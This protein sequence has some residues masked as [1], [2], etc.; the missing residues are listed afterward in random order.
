MLMSFPVVFLGS[1]APQRIIH[2][3]KQEVVPVQAP[4]ETNKHYVISQIHLPGEKIIPSVDVID[5]PGFR[6]L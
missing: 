1:T 4:Q 5:M 2:R 3:N 6:V